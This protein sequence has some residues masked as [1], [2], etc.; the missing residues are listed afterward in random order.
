MELFEVRYAVGWEVLFDLSQDGMNLIPSTL[1]Q[2][3]DR[4]L[5]FR[6]LAGTRREV[7]NNYYSANFIF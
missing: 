3:R 6:S 1:N 7:D 5:Y 4:T 2:G